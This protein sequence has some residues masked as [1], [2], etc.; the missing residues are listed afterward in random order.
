MVD[1]RVYGN[2]AINGDER[3]RE[4]TERIGKEMKDQRMA[5][6]SV[7]FTPP[8]QNRTEQ[9]R[10]SCVELP[11]LSGFVATWRYHTVDAGKEVA[12][13]VVV[14]VAATAVLVELSG[15]SALSS[16]KEKLIFFQ[17]KIYAYCGVILI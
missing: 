3:E 12:I 2:D 11:C 4:S 13:V 8:E 17:K 5:S 7:I 15:G 6:E 16:N 9:S 10:A 14:V 1:G